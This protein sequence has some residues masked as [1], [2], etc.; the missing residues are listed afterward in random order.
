MPQ[1]IGELFAEIKFNVNKDGLKEFTSEI[2]SLKSQINQCVSLLNKLSESAKNFSSVVSKINNSAAKGEAQNKLFGIKLEREE[3]KNAEAYANFLKKIAQWKEIISRTD[4]R[5]RSQKLREFREGRM[6][7]SEER[8]RG[9]S[10]GK[11]GL[12]GG[13]VSALIPGIGRIGSITDAILVAVKQFK[14]AWEE[15]AKRE[16]YRYQTGLDTAKLKDLEQRMAR[17]GFSLGR[18]DVR[19]F[20]AGLQQKM[21]DIRY[22]GGDVSAFTMLG[23]SPYGKDAYRVIRDIGE[24]LKGV[25]VSVAINRLAALGG[26][27]VDTY[28]MIMGL[29]KGSLFGRYAELTGQEDAENSAAYVALKGLWDSVKGLF[30]KIAAFFS[31]LLTPIIK[32]VTAIFDGV[33]SIL[34]VLNFI[35]QGISYA[36]GFIWG[37]LKGVAFYIGDAIAKVVIGLKEIYNALPDW[38]KSGNDGSVT[39][40]AMEYATNPANF[41][42]TT[43]TS[44]GVFNL[45]PVFNGYSKNEAISTV[46]GLLNLPQINAFNND[47]MSASAASFR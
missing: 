45:S 13:L 1:K 40:G 32:F 26:G 41:I 4:V 29:Q 10:S 44:S 14:A 36:A 39:E 7:A 46:G 35:T 27:N 2:G 9:G 38:L 5:E 30:A 42:P 12:L 28:R 20:V 34:T 11:G 16:A 18:Q 6:W 25:D 37:A 24:A 33:S 47:F 15:S 21:I 17:S 23:V 3:I 8:R 22:G 43:S 19:S 31:P